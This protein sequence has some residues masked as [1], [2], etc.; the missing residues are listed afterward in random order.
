MKQKST[1]IGFSEAEGLLLMISLFASA[2]DVSKLTK[3][4]NPI[5]QDKERREQKLEKVKVPQN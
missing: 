5:G 1:S 4:T 3:D 2:H